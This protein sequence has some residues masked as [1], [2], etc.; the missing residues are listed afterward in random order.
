MREVQDPFEGLTIFIM[1]VEAF[2]TVK[3]QKT[4]QYLQRKFGAHGLIAIDESTTI[5][6]IKQ[7]EQ[8]HF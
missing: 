2:S 4:G 1:N 5:K 3:G 7:N 8:R 6:I